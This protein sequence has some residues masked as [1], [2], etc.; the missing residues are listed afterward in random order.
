MRRL[1]PDCGR[2][3]LIV[4]PKGRDEYKLLEAMGRETANIHLGSAGA[5]KRVKRD[6]N[7]RPEGWL[8][9]AA[10]IMVQATTN[11]WRNWSA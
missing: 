11:D 6:L 10:K 3:E 7:K 1:A 2:V 4:L 8:H 5:I 9:D